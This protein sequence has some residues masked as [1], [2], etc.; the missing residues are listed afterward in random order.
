MFVEMVVVV[1]VG[2]ILTNQHDVL[3]EICGKSSVDWPFL[4][5]S[6]LYFGEILEED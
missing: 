1:V 6:T 2:R 4:G 3:R 5:K